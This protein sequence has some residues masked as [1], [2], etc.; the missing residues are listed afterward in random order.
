MKR[1]AIAAFFVCLTFAPQRA[2]AGGVSELLGKVAG[3]WNSK[4]LTAAEAPSKA[5]GENKDEN[6]SAETTSR[7]AGMCQVPRGVQKIVCDKGMGF[8]CVNTPPGG[9]ETDTFLLKGRLDLSSSA[10]ASIRI[11]AQ[12][13]YTKKTT[14]VNTSNADVLDCWNGMLNGSSFCLDGDGLFSARVSL[15]E[16]GPYTVSV[17]ASRYTGDSEEKR[18]RISRV[19][20]LSFDQ[21]KLF[22]DPNI[23]AVA[24][25]DSQ[26]V[27][28][29]TSLLGDCKFCD[30][31][32]SSTGAVEFLV[33]NT[34][35]SN[36]SSRTIACR[37]TI[38]QGG[39]GRFTVGIPVGDGQNSLR[40]RAC[41]VENAGSSS[42]PY[43]SG[44][45][46]R[47]KQEKISLQVV[48]PAYQAA[49][50]MDEFPYIPLRFKLGDT[51]KC[52]RF[53]F[54]RDATK[55]ICPDSSKTYS[56]NLRPKIGIN[57]ASVS[58]EDA[59]QDYSL[60]FAWGKLSSGKVMRAAQVAISDDVI[61]YTLVP[62]VNRYLASSD[63]I[64]QIEGSL[65]DGIKTGIPSDITFAGCG[66]S[67]ILDDYDLVLASRPEIKKVVISPIKFGDSLASFS[68][69]AEGL[70][71]VLNLVEK[72]S[73]PTIIPINVAFKRAVFD[74]ALAYDAKTNSLMVSSPNDDCS[75]KDSDD[76][77]HIPAVLVPKNFE[78]GLNGGDFV[79]CDTSKAFLICSALNA[80]DFFS[81]YLS[82][83]LIDGINGAAYCS[84]SAA[85][86]K[87][88]RR[89]ITKT[90][91]KIKC[92]KGSD[93]KGLLND[94]FDLV[95]EVFA[96]DGFSI[97]GD[98]INLPLNLKFAGS[99]AVLS[100]KQGVLVNEVP[101]NGIAAAINLDALNGLLY[102]L[103]SQGLLDLDVDESFFGK[104]N[105]DFV[106]ECDEFS[107]KNGDESL[108]GGTDKCAADAT[109]KQ[110][111]EKTL[112][113]LCFLRPRVSEMLGAALSEYGY[114]KPNQP[115]MLKIKG[116]RQIAPFI[117]LVDEADVPVIQRV[118]SKGGSQ[119]TTSENLPSAEK[120]EGRLLV[121]E[122]SGL[123]LSFY[124]LALDPSKSIVSMRPAEA[125]PLNGPILRANLTLMLVME[126]SD[127][128]EDVC[129]AGKLTAT[130]R[131][132]SD[133]SRLVIAP[134]DGSNATTV[135]V[136]V[137]TSVLEGKILAGLDGMS[138]KEKAIKF[139][140]PKESTIELGGGG[141][142]GIRD[143]DITVQDAGLK[144]E[145]NSIG[146]LIGVVLR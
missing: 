55:E 81:G 137:M 60:S 144:T 85:L 117:S 124:A 65:R 18:V 102:S 44:I 13:E 10:V 119:S 106:R 49:Y 98:G 54:N 50:D 91:T 16:K 24:E 8:L 136:G 56:I 41:N 74:M 93:C 114:F 32:G 142:F 40:V 94:D 23:R 89:G 140:I 7:I 66:G 3:W 87:M 104:L 51:A 26:F 57:V 5:E 69:T 100:G 121:L 86:T 17:S 77:R 84:G 53:S 131:M 120:I 110:A 116:S 33:E 75:F 64:D 99:G 103:I 126:I 9:V 78:G 36:G 128:K 37:T 141:V 11:S 112:P 101:E 146:A 73:D 129:D 39:Q 92:P 115:L 19:V 63:F 96:G 79:E 134:V 45:N 38:E 31:I 83:G 58:V 111:G 25:T 72:D 20:P 46:F 43:I 68:V 105:F 133:R 42:C 67:S 88:M 52:A 135:P 29:S 143:I 35:T 59:P 34:I 97:N 118:V 138:T 47:G 145:S 1:V 48:S 132:L 139:S 6:K 107:T 71:L 15:P 109:K 14:I 123:E 90:Q 70:R 95:V 80:A 122:L 127:L 2:F 82:D 108:A 130:V 62:A 76:C 21:T 22:Y 125:D 61:N 30:F 28:V 113:A 27:F 4:A 12:N